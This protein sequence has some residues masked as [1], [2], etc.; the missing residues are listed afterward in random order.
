MNLFNQKTIKELLS[1]H[2]TKPNKVMGQ[3]FLVN[4]SVL[5]KIT[6]AAL[7]NSQ[8]IIVE[9]GPGI[10]TLTRALAA[11]AK[12]VIA[13][14][15]DPL[16]IKILQE[17]LRDFDNVEMIQGDALDF[18]VIA[19]PE[20]PRRATK[21]SIGALSEIASPRPRGAAARNDGP[22]KVV[23][24]LP[25]YITSPTIRMF[26]ESQNPPETMVL[27][28]QKEV[29]ERICAKPPRMSILAVSVQ[30]YA[31]AHIIS[32]VPKGNFWPVPGVDSAI[33]KIIPRNYAEINPSAPLRASAKQR[34]NKNNRDLF[35]KIVK[36]GFLHPRKQLQNNL[37]EGLKRSKPEISVWLTKNSIDPLRRAETL[38]MEE[39]ADL[40]NSLQ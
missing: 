16:M 7:V 19:S 35:F 6:E 38:S 11:K 15:K 26:L 28:V 9:I 40:V 31:M 33:I 37:S 17:T 20:P 14:E 10:G 25:Y 3:N 2:N 1:K 22:Y 23:A 30:F 32:L 24:N 27:M 4:A 21:Q 36:A 12:K 39:W 18:P 34:G 29:A 13:I 5:N 8:D